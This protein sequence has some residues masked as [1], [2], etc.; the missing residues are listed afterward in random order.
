MIPH[1]DVHSALN[2]ILT[3]VKKTYKFAAIAIVGPSGSGK[4]TLCRQ[5][6]TDN[7]FRQYTLTP[8]HLSDE[9]A[10][11]VED[12]ISRAFHHHLIEPDDKRPIAIFVDD[13]DIWAPARIRTS[14][15]VRIIAALNHEILSL[16]NDHSFP[17]VFLATACSP[18]DVHTSLLTPEHIS[19]LFS[20]SA[21]SLKQRQIVA[22]TWLEHVFSHV[23]KGATLRNIAL[24]IAAITPGFM[25]A[26]MA[27][28]FSLLQPNVS[29]MAASVSPS[30]FFT[31]PFFRQTIQLVTP[32]LL[33]SNSQ[34]VRKVTQS[35]AS[36]Q[37]LYGLESQVDQLAQ[38]LNAV[39]WNED[40][41]DHNPADKNI[42]LALQQLGTFR[43]LLIH[44]RTGCGKTA[45]ANKAPSLLPQNTVNFLTVEST[46]IVSSTIGEA[47][48][49]LS[50]VFSI[51]R[52]IAP[53]VIFMENIDV[54]AP[55][56]EDGWDG[57][58][59]TQA[60]NRLLSTLLVEIDG[61]EE[62]NAGSTVFVIATTRSLELLDSALLRPGRF[63]LHIEVGLPDDRA[64]V[65]MLEAFCE[66][67][68]V[69]LESY[70]GEEWGGGDKFLEIS[71]GW[72]AADVMSY[73]RR[74]V[75]EAAMRKT[76]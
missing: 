21:L 27:R 64:K 44:G 54:L 66:E 29:A 52:A 4:T 19:H 49:N 69:V 45:L 12:T 59:S 76:I 62:H 42:F 32:S 60:F 63:D 68:N 2:H 67:R 70:D 15:D 38:C 36:S 16:Y 23:T 37:V 7:G 56:R 14:S 11:E 43:G 57:G 31:S 26:D 28:L 6:I 40:M 50:H 5:V 41:S 24:E 30:E 46:S 51:A 18:A 55:L 65:Q 25:H 74:K 72:T 3:D 58:S 20:L 22:H 73:G 33:S 48:R 39:F 47:E 8:R 1:T 10:G 53:T 35:Q 9:H 17:I 71:K 75:M 13:L 61:V 34:L